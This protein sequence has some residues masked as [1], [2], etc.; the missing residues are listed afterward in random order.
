VFFYET[1]EIEKSFV[2]F[3]DIFSAAIGNAKNS[4]VNLIY[5]VK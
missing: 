3:E 5:S 1:P 2:D 4:F